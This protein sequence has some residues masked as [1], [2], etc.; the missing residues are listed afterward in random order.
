MISMKLTLRPSANPEKKM[1]SLTLR[2]V[3]N[4]K[5]KSITL[6]D[7]RI[8]LSEWDEKKGTI[9]HPEDDSERAICLREVEAIVRNEWKVIESHLAMIQKKEN[10]SLDELSALYKK[11]QQGD[12]RL[13]GYAEKCA[14]E[15]ESH[16][17][18]RSARSCR[19]AASILVAFNNGN[20]ILL[21]HI[22]AQLIKSFE[23][24]LYDAGKMPNT[25]SHYMRTLRAIYNKSTKEKRSSFRNIDY[26]FTDV[27]TG[28]APTIKRSLSVS[29][30]RKLMNIDFDELLMKSE[31]ADKLRRAHEESQRRAHL[32]FC[33][34]IYARGMCFIDLAHLKKQN[35]GRGFLRYIRRKTG[36]PIDVRIT[37][38]MDRI[39]KYF[40]PEVEKSNFLFPIIK[41]ANRGIGISYESALCRQNRL[42]KEIAELAGIDKPI[43]TH[44]ARHSW[45]TIAKHE[46]ISVRTIS[47]C[48]GHRSEKTTQIYMDSLENS[49]LDAANDVVLSALSGGKKRRK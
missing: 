39:I 9:I 2:L 33:F 22:D 43:S 6:P 35:A 31:P 20:N 24:F 38:E 16:G 4:R 18:K 27:Y 45:A 25:V 12:D 26:P 41:E 30:A 32:Y 44:W 49:L 46:N 8:L 13:L 14:T 28:V 3:H 37:Q 23:T 5:S 1:G 40:A 21:D 42:I 17:R 19:T 29:E 48:L 11:K 15:F 36:R 10:Y 47:E 7:C 34:C